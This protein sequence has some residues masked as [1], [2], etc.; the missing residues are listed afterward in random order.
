M[1]YQMKCSASNKHLHLSREDLD[2]L[3]GEGYELTFKKALVQPGQ[4]ASEEKVD[5]VGPKSTFHGIRVLGP[6]RPETQVEL[7]MTDARQLGVQA[8]LRESGDLAGTPGCKIIG[9]KGE[10]EIDHGVIV[11][12]RH[13]HFDPEAA[14][15][16]GVENGQIIKIKI[17]S[18]ERST[19]F[20]DVVC[21]VGEKHYREVHLDTDES[22]AAGLGP[23]AT[24]ELILD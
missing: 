3:F 16:A 9:P 24:C 2:T 14:A 17:D 19:V 11:A 5:I 4:F 21:R 12:K 1:A 8:P 7:A 10:I 6:V 20:G 13:A 18:E 15:E 22:N 23:D